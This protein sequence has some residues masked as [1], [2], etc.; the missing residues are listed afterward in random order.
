MQVYKVK[1]LSVNTNFQ[2]S[3]N[4]HAL[5]TLIFINF[6][7]RIDADL[8]IFIRLR[9]T[10]DFFENT[11]Y[12]L[13]NENIVH[14]YFKFY[15]KKIIYNILKLKGVW[16]RSLSNIIWVFFIYVWVKKYVGMFKMLKKLLKMPYQIGPKFLTPPMTCPF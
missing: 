11:I 8:H 4:L 5:T 14:Y 10:N 15:T 12:L 3:T 7:T 9:L 16:Q 13:T 2:S 1:L 6:L